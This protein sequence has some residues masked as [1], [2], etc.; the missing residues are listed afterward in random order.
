VQL[1]SG[2]A[3][4]ALV[5]KRDVIRSEDAEKM[6]PMY[7]EERV[8]DLKRET[9]TECP[10]IKEIIR[11]FSDA[12][13]DIGSF[14]FSPEAAR[15]FISNI[16]GRFSVKLFGRALKQDR[17]DDGFQLWRYLHE[18]GFM[19]ARITD[20]REKRGFRHITPQQEPDLV[21]PSRWND[22]QK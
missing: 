14:T 13:Y 8:D 21:S 12:E 9:D 22:M 2:L 17:A 5:Q 19:N 20:K 18:I 11:S 7:S 16:P 3:D 15:E 1:V 4:S 10:Q 6:M